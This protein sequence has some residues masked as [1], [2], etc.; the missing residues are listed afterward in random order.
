MP[1]RYT[2]LVEDGEVIAVELNGKKY[3]DPALVPSPE[4]RARLLHLVASFSEREG[5]ASSGT[6]PAFPRS[7]PLLFLSVALL[8]LAIA[9]FAGVRT[10]LARSREQNAPGRVIDLV[11]RRASSGQPF[12][13]PVVEI[14]LPDRSTR[15]IEVSEGSWPPAYE[16]GDPV[17]VAYDPDRPASVRIKSLG[18]AFGSWTLS[19][20][21]GVLG[22]AFLAGAWFA[23]WILKAAP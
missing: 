1:R 3:E 10:G 23:R 15:A 22:A 17:T 11:E 6:V 20:I 16:I 7:I 12:Y 9:V 8:S 2:L 4:D 14:T 21:T 18:S 19:I 13:Y 5:T